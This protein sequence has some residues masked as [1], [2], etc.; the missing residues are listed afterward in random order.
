LLQARLRSRSRGPA[1]T[2]I[3]LVGRD[4]M[5]GGDYAHAAH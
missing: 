5:S 3:P 1:A 4:L 2:P